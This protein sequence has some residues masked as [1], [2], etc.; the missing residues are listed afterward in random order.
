V[1]GMRLGV[2]EVSTSE[3]PARL[4]LSACVQ[5]GHCRLGIMFGT[6]LA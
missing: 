2:W 6:L 1:L 3:S 4:S 5:A